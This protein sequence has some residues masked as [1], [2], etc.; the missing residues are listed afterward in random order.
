M[1]LGSRMV[2]QAFT[3][4]NFHFHHVRSCK[5][6]TSWIIAEDNLQCVDVFL[7]SRSHLLNMIAGR[8]IM[9]NFSC[10]AEATDGTAPCLQQKCIVGFILA[11]KM[12]SGMDEIFYLRYLFGN[13]RILPKVFG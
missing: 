5:Y 11:E 13:S 8:G 3:Q 10:G 9:L 7:V 2:G 1:A 6:F 12:H 4:R